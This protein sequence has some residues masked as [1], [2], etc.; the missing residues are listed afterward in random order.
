MSYMKE[1]FIREREDWNR[2]PVTRLISEAEV[3]KW[4]NSLT[5]QERCWYAAKAAGADADG[6]I[7][8]AI[9]K[10]WKFKTDA[11]REHLKEAEENDAY[12]PE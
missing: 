11:Y 9:H 10:P 3:E 5:E 7:L 4:W 8:Y 2:M 12:E 1:K 6:E